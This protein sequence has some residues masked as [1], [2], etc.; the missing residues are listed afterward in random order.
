MKQ[1]SI[2]INNLNWKIAGEAGYGIKASGLMFAKACA[3]GG[4]Q[5]FDYSEY[6]SLIRGGHN[7]YQVN[8]SEEE[9]FSPQSEVNLLV[10]LN[11][12]TIDFHKD[13]L[14]NQ[15]GVIYEQEDKKIEITS[16]KKNNCQLFPVPLSRLAKENGGKEIMRNSVALGASF[17]LLNYDFKYLQSVIQ[18]SFQKKGKEVIDLNVKIAEAGFN[19]VSQNFDVAKYPYQLKHLKSSPRMVLT[20]NEAIALGA[21]QAGCKF[22]SAYPM[23]PATPILHYLA[24]QQ[25]NHNLIVKQTEDEI[26]AITMAIGANYAGVRAMTCTSG[27]GFSLMVEGLGLAG[28]TETPLVIAEVQRPG[29]ATGLPTWTEQADLR[30]LIHAAQGEFPRIIIAPGDVEESFYA[31]QSA[32]NL[33][34]KYQLP[35]FILSDKFLAESNKS[36]EFFDPKIIKIERGALLTNTQLQKMRK[37]RRYAFAKSGISPRSIP[38]QKGG[39]FNANSDEHDQFGY[40]SEDAENRARMMEKRLGKLDQVALEIPD[41][42][43]YGPAKADLTLIAWGSTKG[44]IIEAMKLFEKNRIRVNFLHVMYVYPFP[45]EKVKEVIRK[46]KKMV[47]I[48]NNATAQLGS[49][50]R[51]FTGIEIDRKLLKFSG[52][53][54]Y[55][56]EIYQYLTDNFKK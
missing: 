49:L 33:A 55:P 18:D 17:A 5:I 53:P 32:F 46:A 39:I 24:S 48:E 6:P 35:V 11:Q 4:L 31:T 40:S 23:T 13:E 12:D 20:G 51:E 37:Y 34:E 10:A 8:V 15:A 29:P 3:R 2:S 26:S 43:L 52:R 25:K 54:F 21:I 9:V 50:I 14:S 42:I 22:I 19:Y 38:G 1:N 41:P 30:F 36:Q 28:M 47:L 45:A 7:T 44:P 56:S 27:G 16:L